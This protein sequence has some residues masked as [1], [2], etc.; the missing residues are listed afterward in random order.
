MAAAETDGIEN[1][2][3]TEPT[4]GREESPHVYHCLLNYFNNYFIEL[5]QPKSPK[6]SPKKR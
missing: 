4:E 2:E 3:R 1:S 5:S 6:K